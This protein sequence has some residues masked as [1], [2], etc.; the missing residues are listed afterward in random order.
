MICLFLWEMEARLFCWYLVLDL[1][2]V[3]LNLLSNGLNMSGLVDDPCWWDSVG[4]GGSWDDVS[5]GSNGGSVV[6]N[7]WGGGKRGSSSEAW[8][9]AVIAEW[10]TG[11]GEASWEDDLALSGGDGGGE[12]NSE[13]FHGFG[14]W[15]C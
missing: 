5:W 13:G 9:K 14:F 3:L 10:Q 2:S 7:S 4:L 12:D 15:S 1:V 6:G 11:V 8:G